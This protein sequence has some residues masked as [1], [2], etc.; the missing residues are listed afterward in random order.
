M[1][2]VT[3]FMGHGR[4]QEPAEFTLQCFHTQHLSPQWMFHPC[5]TDSCRVS[6]H[7][8]G[9]RSDAG[10]DASAA[11][12]HVAGFCHVS[13]D[14][15]SSRIRRVWTRPRNDSSSTFLT[16][17]WLISVGD[18][19]R[20]LHLSITDDGLVV[21]PPTDADVTGSTVVLIGTLNGDGESLAVWRQEVV[22][23][24][25]LM[26]SFYFGNKLF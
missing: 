17:V 14:P 2:D 12:Y 5:S 1:V 7:F 10:C 11:V 20:L 23:N 26:L 16:D 21:A 18:R 3:A 8:C 15:L 24:T 25:A 22:S 13:T 19:I 6:S 4:K 9:E